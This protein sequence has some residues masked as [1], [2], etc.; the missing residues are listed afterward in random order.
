MLITRPRSPHRFVLSAC[1]EDWE[2]FHRKY[3]HD[4]IRPLRDADCAGLVHFGDWKFTQ[5]DRGCKL[6]SRPRSRIDI[7]HRR[8]KHALISHLKESQ[9]AKKETPGSLFWIEKTKV[10][11]SSTEMQHSTLARYPCPCCGHLVFDEPSGS[12]DICH[13]C[14]WEDDG[15]Q[16]AYPMMEGG[17][18]SLSLFESQRNFLTVGACEPRFIQ[19]V[20]PPGPNEPRDPAWRPF[21]PATD[22]HLNVDSPEDD[23]LWKS[24]TPEA[25]LYYWQPDYWLAGRKRRS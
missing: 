24:A 18:N 16:L 2:P 9:L 25:N 19:N 10:S 4:F 21:D 3:Y 8:L 23:E 17:A 15:L 14:F 5:P 7:M 1:A 11:Q 6:Y 20:R 22:P 12:Y 13:V